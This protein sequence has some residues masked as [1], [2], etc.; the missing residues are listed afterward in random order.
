MPFSKENIS[1]IKTIDQVIVELDYIIKHSVEENNLFGYFGALYSLVTKKVRSSIEA[2]QFE[3]NARME[4]LDV[5]F[6]LRYFEAYE[7][8]T[9]SEKT[10]DSWAEAFNLTD[11]SMILQFLLLGMN[12]HIGLDLGIV[13]CEVGK[14]NMASLKNDFFKIN[15]ILFSM[16]DSVQSKLGVIF[17][18]LRIIDALAGRL[19]EAVT[20]FSIA[21]ARD[22]AW[23]FA[24]DLSTKTNVYDYN[25][26]IRTRDIKVS[27]FGTKLSEPGIFLRGL[28]SLVKCY[29]KKYTNQELIKILQN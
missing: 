2:G 10:M 13:S 16:I 5:I 20:S 3:D 22:A 25:Q 21:I 11:K 1:S 19:D 18:P 17:P 28:I 26:L 4:H 29:E 27:A 12:A 23:D 6:A 24:M 8:Y 15:E 7:Q 9:S 14:D